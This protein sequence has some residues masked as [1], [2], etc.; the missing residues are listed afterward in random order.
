MAAALPHFDSFDVHADGAVAQRWRKWIKRLENLF[1]AADIKD[2]K[3]Q[4]ALLLHYAGEEVSEIFDSLLETGDDYATAKEK[5][6]EYFDPKKNTE[7]EIYTFRQ[8]KQNPGES[9]NAFHARLR[10]LSATCEFS[11]IEREVK[12]Q[13]IQSCLSQRLRRKALKDSTMTLQKL[14]EEARAMEIAETQAKEIES[15]G[16]ANALT[17]KISSKLPKKKGKKGN[18]FNCGGD[19]PHDSKTGCPARNRRCNACHKYGHYAKYCRNS[20][21]CESGQVQNSQKGSKRR[22]RPS[23]SESSRSVN[24]VK[25]KPVPA[26]YFSSDD[27]YTFVVRPNPNVSAPFVTL[28]VS[29]AEYNFLVDSGASVNIVSAEMY[30]I[31]NVELTSCDN[32]CVCFQL[33]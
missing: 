30:K 2:K 28:K 9:M 26:P 31:I 32:P 18:C 8:A 19:W 1:V 12:S 4:P 33:I 29:R 10:Q 14:L 3:R 23:N 21:D 5:L 24:M 11:D 27:E 25:E 15:T 20:Q 16:S 13:I 22:Q 7:F 17:T 6:N